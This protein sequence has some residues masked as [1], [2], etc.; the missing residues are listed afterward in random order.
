MNQERSREAEIRKQEHAKKLKE[1]QRRKENLQ[2][3]KE[4][5]YSLFSATNPQ[6]RGKDLETVLNGYFKEFQILIKE[7]FTRTGEPGEGIIEQIDGITILKNILPGFICCRHLRR[8]SLLKP[9]LLR[10]A[11]SRKAASL[12]P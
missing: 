9:K 7:N 10:K 5:L 1:L 6:K 2:Q 4:D 3:L 8:T 11:A 12:K